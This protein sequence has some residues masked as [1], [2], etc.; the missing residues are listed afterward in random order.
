VGGSAWACSDDNQGERAP[1]RGIPLQHLPMGAVS[2]RVHVGR[3]TRS[4]CYT[5]GP[6]IATLT[7]PC[8]DACRRLLIEAAAAHP[9]PT[10]K[11]G[12][13]N[14]SH[15]GGGEASPYAR[16]TPARRG[17]APLP[18]QIRRDEGREGG[19]PAEGGGRTLGG[20]GGGPARR[21]LSVVPRP[22]ARPVR[23]DGLAARRAGSTRREQEPLSPSPPASCPAGFWG[24][25]WSARPASRRLSACVCVCSACMC[26]GRRPACHL[27]PVHPPS[28]PL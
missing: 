4:H 13:S 12:P 2:V 18:A 17:A 19:R 21:R 22:R 25:R 8:R 7:H 23:S 27:P 15:L 26:G 11:A 24:G 1:L 14:R 9:G 3:N 28:S 5:H 6:L 16:G 20:A 10:I